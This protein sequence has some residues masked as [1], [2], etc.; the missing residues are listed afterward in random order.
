MRYLLDSKQRKNQTDGRWRRG[1]A[2]PDS[3]TAVRASLNL[4]VEPFG[5]NLGP[6]TDFSKPNEHSGYR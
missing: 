1:N 2:K 5:A 3:M 4:L 6:E